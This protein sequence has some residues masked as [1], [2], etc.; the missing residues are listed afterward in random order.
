M[1]GI[2]KNDID[3]TN[4]QQNNILQTNEESQKDFFSP[5]YTYFIL[6]IIK[7]LIYPQLATNGYFHVRYMLT[8]FLLT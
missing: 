8:S 2:Y 7:F 6:E 5:L 3:Y 4:D 1:D